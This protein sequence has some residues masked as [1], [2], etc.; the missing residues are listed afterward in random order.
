MNQLK[1]KRT[2]QEHFLELR[3]R[4]LLSFL[5]LIPSFIICWI[6]SSDILDILR[7][8]LKPFLKNTNG[9]LIFT[10]PMDQFIA[11]LQV[12]AFFA[13]LLS[14]PYWLGQFWC[15][16][17]PG[18]YKK[19]K[20]VF[21][22]FWGFGILL[23]LTGVCFAYFVVFP[24]VFST[25]IPFG[26]GVDQAFITIKEY[27]SFIIRFT[28][29]FA[30]VFEMPIVLL[31]LCRL[32]LLSPESLKKS[33]RIAWVILSILAAF[34][35]PPDILSMLLLLFPLIGLYELSLWITQLFTPNKST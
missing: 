8:P 34:I 6:F 20:K 2:L 4:F 23:F 12:S 17:S 11:H 10:G 19:E 31:A 35:T 29:V 7:H 28:L 27:L 5:S 22:L 16:I 32:G 26:N 14:S 30:L 21:I 15:F 3:K 24:I 9:G 13:V 18:L 33:R 25:L 1:S